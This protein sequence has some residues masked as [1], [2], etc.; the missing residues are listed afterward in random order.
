MTS[1]GDWAFSGCD[2][3]TLTVARDSY[4]EQYCKENGLAYTYTDGLD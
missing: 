2:S 1:I 4:A 3:L